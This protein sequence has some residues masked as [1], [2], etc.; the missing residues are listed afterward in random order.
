MNTKATEVARSADLII[1][2]LLA[3][4]A[5]EQVALVCDSQSEMSMVHALA[6][7]AG[8]VGAEYTILQMPPRT[9]AR[10]NDLTP[11]IDR[12]LEAADCLIGLTGSCGAPTY[13]KA[14]KH[15]F[16]EKRLRAISMVMRKLDNYT[17]GGARAD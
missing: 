9:T 8:S 7:V 1:R 5:G 12:A 13:S 3:V 16:D 2:R 17:E 10:K 11:P 15:L 4:K 14:V 6:G